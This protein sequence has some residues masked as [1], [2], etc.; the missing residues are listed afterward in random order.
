MLEVHTLTEYMKMHW[1]PF[2]TLVITQ[3]LFEDNIKL[4]YT[5]IENY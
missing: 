3:G 1:E 2:K 5:G 4:T